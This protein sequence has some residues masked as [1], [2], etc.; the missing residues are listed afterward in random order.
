MGYQVK[1]VEDNLGVTRKA[2][3]FWEEKGLMSQNRD[4]KYRDYSDEDI[5]RIWAIKV[6]QGMGYSLNEIKDIVDD[7]N[8]DFEVSLTK[9]IKELEK[10]KVEIEKHLGYAQTIKMA[11]RF[12]A[13]PKNMG[14]VKFDDFYEKVL[15]EWNVNEDP[16]AKRYKGL[17]EICLNTPERE[18]KNA[19]I[20]KMFEFLQELQEVMSNIDVIMREKIIPLEILKRQE[21]GATDQEVQLLVKIL[22]EN[23]ICSVPELGRM[24]KN[25]FVRFEAAS[26][27]FGDVAKMKEREYGKKGCEFIANAIAVFGGYN[28]YSEVEDSGGLEW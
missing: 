28:C 21:K 4:R 8:F 19:D 17:L 26:Y 3:R 11:G 6:L 13:R 1:W 2:L 18:F 15:N 27:L 7:E 22:Y 10:K 5:D 23:R 9:K 25:E 24:T 14:S 16:K 20:E 12:P